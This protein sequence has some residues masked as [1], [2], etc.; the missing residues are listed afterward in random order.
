MDTLAIVCTYNEATNIE[1]VINDILN[2]GLEDIEVLIADDMSPDQTYKIVE[3]LS[4]KDSRVHLL[5]RKTNR[6]RGY[7]AIDAFKWALQR[8]AKH[9]VELDG[10]G[11]H[12]P[13]YIKNFRQAINSCDVVI[14]SRFVCGGTDSQRDF[15]RKS[16]SFFARKYLR[17]ILGIDVCDPTSGY[18]MFKQDV[19]K[20]FVHKLKAADP[21]IV[22]EMLYY[23]KKSKAS[24]KEYPIDFLERISGQSKL[25]PLTLFKYLFKVL[26]LRILN[27]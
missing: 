22:T 9:I 20:Y 1:K 13:K 14:G 25:K 11:S 4:K 18:R 12:N 23:T 10:D 17:F 21:F 8:D 3:D 27:N 19:I 6:G 16:V 24:I 15:I 7:A 5:L 2:C 26:K